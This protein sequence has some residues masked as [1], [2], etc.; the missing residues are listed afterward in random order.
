MILTPWIADYEQYLRSSGYAERTIRTR[1]KHL[2]CLARF[3]ETRPSESLEEFR[4][5]E[6][7]DFIDYWIGHQ[8]W[9]KTSRGLSRKSRFAP[10]HHAA[11]G[12]SLRSFFRWARSAG[13]LKR[14]VFPLRAPVRGNYIFP[15]VA[16]YLEFCREH[17]GLARN[18]L[19]QIELFV[20]RFDRFLSHH[21]VSDWNEMMS[22]HIDDFVRQEADRNVKRIQRIQKILR[23]LFRWLFSQGRIERDWAQ[24]LRSPRS[25][26]LAHTPR[27]LPPKDALRLLENIDRSQRGGKRDFSICL[28]AASLGVRASEIAQLRLQDLDW[29]KQAVRFEQVKTGNVLYL[30]LSESLVAALADYLKQ[31]RPASLYRNVFLRLTSPCGPLAAAS[32]SNL[33]RQRMRQAGIGGSAHGLRHAFAQEL[34]RTGVGFSTLQELLGHRHFSSTQIYTKLDLGRL[35]EVA[36]NDGEDY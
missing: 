8:P 6:T 24:A 3:L 20:R 21:Q 34:L 22:R 2:H 26:Q 5:E 9:A 27:A 29:R 15:E 1:L 23:G 12:Y 14:D 30:P 32:V 11:L 36:Q 7:I 19:L 18:S 33:I 4:A 35:R 10:R 17:R 25:Y 28:L 31:E 16:A 13:Y